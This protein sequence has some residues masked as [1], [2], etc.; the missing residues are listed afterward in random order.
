MKIA[1][2]QIAPK[3][4][5]PDSNLKR[6]LDLVRRARSKGADLVV[7]PELSLTGYM[8]QDLVPEVA[9][10]ARRGVRLRALSQASRRIGIVAG[11]VEDRKSVV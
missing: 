3:L 7:F 11:F 6:H 4:G 2:A 5:D 1:L 9:E 8:L 10:E